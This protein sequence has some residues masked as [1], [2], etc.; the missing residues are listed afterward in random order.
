MGEYSSSSKRES[1]ECSLALL[2]RFGV[3][4]ISRF[5][6]GRLHIFYHP[7]V[8]KTRSRVECFKLPYCCNFN[9]TKVFLDT[10]NSHSRIVSILVD[11]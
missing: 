7:C 6:A 4:C 2:S 1:H 8:H 3:F 5:T 11:I 10:E 9:F